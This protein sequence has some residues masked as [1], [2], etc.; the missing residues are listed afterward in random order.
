MSAWR[1]YP[2]DKRS[3]VSSLKLG[4]DW[5]IS[6]I[7]MRADIE[8]DDV[9]RGPLPSFKEGPVAYSHKQIQNMQEQLKAAKAEAKTAR[10][11]AAALRKHIDEK[12]PEPK[13]P[14]RTMAATFTAI[15]LAA[16]VL[17]VAYVGY[18]H[19][20]QAPRMSA[21]PAVVLAP[22][23][24]ATQFSE[25]KPAATPPDTKF[26]DAVHRLQDDF[27]D[28]P[29]EDTQVVQEINLRHAGGPAPCPLEWVNGEVALSLQGKGTAPLTL[30]E[31]VNQCANAVEALH[32]ERETT[33]RG[34]SQKKH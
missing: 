27:G 2:G 18:I 1:N 13:I 25:P 26:D 31:A 11:E 15:L 5:S 20:S 3:L 24:P 14:F 12:P 33:L 4:L 29:E 19:Q 23:P 17:K 21:P 8:N 16:A 22:D 10:R 28:L 32:A 7:A 30:V 34:A 6:Q 9:S